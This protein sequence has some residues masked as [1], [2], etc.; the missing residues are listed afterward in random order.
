MTKRS[1]AS[2]Q[3]A[4]RQWT[5]AERQALGHAAN[6]QVVEDDSCVNFEDIPRLTEEQLASMVRLRDVRRRVP[7][8]VLLDTRVL[9]WLKS[10]GEGH[11]TRINDILMNLTEAE[12]KAEPRQ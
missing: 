7:V 12:H 4:G 3:P 1:S 8:S 9:D 6:R 11:L 2:S 10:K 5:E